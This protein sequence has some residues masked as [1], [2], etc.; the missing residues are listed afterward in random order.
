MNFAKKL[1]QFW[2]SR[3]WIRWLFFPLSI[4]FYCL[5]QLK[6]FFYF[7]GLYKV[8][9]GN[10]PILVVGNINVGGTG[11][12]PFI[13][14][15][16]SEL[17]KQNIR[18][19]IVSR[20]YRSNAKNYPHL[21]TK[22]D[23]VG[24]IGDEAYMQ[25]QTLNVPMAIDANRF[26]AVKLLTDQQPLDLIISDDGL[27]H[28]RMGRQYEVALVDAS[29]LFGNGMIMPLGPLREPIS[30]LKSVDL[31]VQNGG[32]K[33]SPCLFNLNKNNTLMTIQS[34]GLVH[35]YSQEIVTL[36]N[37]K[38]KKVNAVCGI[39]NPQRF[40]D[41]LRPLCA[42]LTQF[43]FP[44]HHHFI[45]DDFKGLNQD[46]VIMTE[47]DAVKCRSFA[48]DNWYYLKVS[49]SLPTN[50]MNQLITNIKHYVLNEELHNNG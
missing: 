6:R 42:H 13:T 8:Q 26:S 4:P 48:K 17:K 31:I 7:I 40:F 27:Q 35:L 41:T 39:G 44:D 15:L 49:A 36:N 10:A 11:K 19:G 22:N 28:Y 21:V 47:K 37:L 12:T 9:M 14:L 5:V 25:F 1:E 2:Y 50:D 18:L 45:E 46:I 3:H 16:V 29:R 38:E 32:Q 24:L 30:R 23:D 34:C 43:I 33:I 20:G